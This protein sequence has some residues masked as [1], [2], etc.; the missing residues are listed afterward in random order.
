M[1]VSWIISWGLRR[2]IY[3]DGLLNDS[4]PSPPSPSAA[5][6]WTASPPVIADHRSRPTCSTPCATTTP[7][8]SRP[9]LAPIRPQ[10]PR[11]RRPTAARDKGFAAR[12]P[13]GRVV[14]PNCSSDQWSVLTSASSV[15]QLAGVLGLLITAIAL[16]FDRNS[17]EGRPHHRAVRLGGADPHAGQLSYS[18]HDGTVVSPS[19]ATAGASAPSRGHRVRLP[20]ACWLLGTTALFGGLG[21]MLASH[22]VGSVAEAGPDVAATGFLAD[23]G[24]WLTFTSQR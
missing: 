17:R 19:T 1:A 6:W 12:P 13:T 8:T 10:R 24:G 5:G 16:L 11:H 9:G 15:S 21:W 18:H 7:K 22:A 4:R 3:P 14:R 20:P 23:L 2:N